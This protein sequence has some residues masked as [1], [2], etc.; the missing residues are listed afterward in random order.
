MRNTAA[1]S[2][3][4]LGDNPFQSRLREASGWLLWFG[5]GMVALGIA[6]IVNPRV[7]TLVAELLVGWLLW[8]SGAFT[9]FA[10]FSIHGTG[11]FF[12]ALLLGLLSTRQACSCSPIR[13]PALSRSR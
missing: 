8:F 12:D 2:N 13:M 7:S 1:M 6:A 5:L 11:P 4:S 3:A 10:S 9:F